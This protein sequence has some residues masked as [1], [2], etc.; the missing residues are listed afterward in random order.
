MKFLKTWI[1]QGFWE[2]SSKPSR[3]ALDFQMEVMDSMI[4]EKILLTNNCCDYY[5]TFPLI[6]DAE[7]EDLPI[8]G[9]ALFDNEETLTLV[10]KLPSGDVVFLTF[11]GV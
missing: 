4:R 8:Y 3:G 7:F 2:K 11:G 10:T 9:M 5:P 6:T 1:K